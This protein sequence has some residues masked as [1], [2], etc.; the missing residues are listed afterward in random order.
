MNKTPSPFCIETEWGKLELT[1]GNY[2]S[3]I[4]RKNEIF[5]TV[6]KT[7]QISHM[8][9]KKTLTKNMTRSC[10][11]KGGLVRSLQYPG[12]EIALRD[13]QQNTFLFS[14]GRD[15]QLFETKIHIPSIE[16]IHDNDEDTEWIEIEDN[17]QNMCLSLSMSAYDKTYRR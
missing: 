13:R 1:K 3:L 16:M 2:L 17:V 7:K 8:E 15:R 6:K 4:K 11:N 12:N 5:K 9:N 10:K 14:V